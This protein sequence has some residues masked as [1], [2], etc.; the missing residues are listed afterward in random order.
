MAVKA[1][2][3]DLV[4]GRAGRGYKDGGPL[5]GACFLEMAGVCG[6]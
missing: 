2:G 4:L 6:Q 5:D 1:Q 3:T